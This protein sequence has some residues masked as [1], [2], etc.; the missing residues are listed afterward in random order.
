MENNSSTSHFREPASPRFPPVS[1]RALWLLPLGIVLVE[2]ALRL[3]PAGFMIRTV[4]ARMAEIVSLPAPKLQIM[5]DSVTAR[6]NAANLAEAADLPVET[7]GNYSLPGTSPVFALFTLRRE[8]A[9]GRVPARILFA[10]HPANLE[11]PMIDRFIGRFGTAEECADLLTHGVSLPDWLFGAACRASLAMRNREEFRLAITQGDFGFFRTLRTP[12]AS[13]MNS[14]TKIAPSSAPPPLALVPA[15]FPAQLSAPFFVDAVNARY[16]D[17]FCDLAE[18]RGI[19]V[20]WVT[21]PV[22]GLFQERAM[23][24]NGA[25]KFQSFLAGLEAR[26][27]NVTLL[28]P[29]I[30]VYPDSCFA[31]AWH[32]NAYGALRFSTELG[33]ALKEAAPGAGTEIQRSP[34][35][36][37]DGHRFRFAG[38]STL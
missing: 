29:E 31:D 24:G 35:N 17:L 33:V 25:A 20:T 15:D 6:I 8:L 37:P 26:H 13:V 7:V 10:P 5:G 28:H 4:R 2:A 38:N 19:Q 22:I 12:A 3:M 21:V 1:L 9:A 16:I 36:W 14:R 32:L 30:E 23:S 34:G 11:T 18:S 27:R